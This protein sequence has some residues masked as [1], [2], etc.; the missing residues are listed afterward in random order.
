MAKKKKRIRVRE[1][2]LTDIGLFRKLWTM[3]LEQQVKDGSIV[4]PSARTM[5]AYERLFNVYVEKEYNGLVLFVADKG[6]LMYG[7]AVSPMECSLGRM[8]TSWGVFVVPGL[9][10]EKIRFA[11]LEYAEE[12]ATAQGFDGILMDEYRGSKPQ[13][14]N[15]FEA[16]VTTLYRPLD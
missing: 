4:V 10:D 1:A 12:W 9:D 8:V 11:M 7:D 16:V 5:A 3:F 2:K 6:V 14:N 13:E 15:N